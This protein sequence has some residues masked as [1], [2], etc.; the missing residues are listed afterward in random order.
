MLE[1]NFPFQ[2]KL[3]RCAFLLHNFIRFNQHYQDEFD[4][5]DD[6][7]MNNA[8]NENCGNIGGGKST[9]EKNRLNA[10]RNGIA[11]RMWDQ[12][13]IYVAENGL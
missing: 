8:G 7:E 11:Q 5:E 2:V 4:V 9:A 10:W 6:V 12:Y 1:Y 3:V 13:Q